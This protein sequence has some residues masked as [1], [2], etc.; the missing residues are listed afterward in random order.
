MASVSDCVEVI[1]GYLRSNDC[2]GDAEPQRRNRQI[3]YEIVQLQKGQEGAFYKLLECSVC[4]GLMG[5]AL[6]P[7]GDPH[8]GL[9]LSPVTLTCGHSFCRGCLNRTFAVNQPCVCPLCRTAVPLNL[10]DASRRVNILPSKTIADI[11]FR[12][13]PPPDSVV[14]GGGGSG[15]GSGGS[16][17][18]G[19]GGGG[20][21][22]GGSGGGSF[23]RSPRRT[24][25][26][27]RRTRRTAGRR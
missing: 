10:L 24:R 19:S 16:G 20:S 23:R 14:S 18:G 25:Q 4:T 22:G 5:T 9:G 13:T 3:I 11:V 8:G 21:G 26:R 7:I 1:K 17:G 15:S 27:T 12:I 2:D 6:D